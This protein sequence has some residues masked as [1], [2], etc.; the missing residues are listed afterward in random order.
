MGWTYEERVV[1][2][3][4]VA[5]EDEVLDAQNADGELPLEKCQDSRGCTDEYIDD[6]HTN[7][8]SANVQG[9]NNL[10][11]TDPC[12]Y[13]EDGFESAFLVAT[14]E[15]SASSMAGEGMGEHWWVPVWT[16]YLVLTCADSCGLV[17]HDRHFDKCGL[18]GLSKHVEKCDPSPN[19]AQLE[20][21]EERLCMRPECEQ[22]PLTQHKFYAPRSVRFLS[23]GKTLPPRRVDRYLWKKKTESHTTFRSS[24]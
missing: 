15:G 12:E 6:P 7:H 19:C 23:F 5:G 4:E 1:V 21:R 17:G 13:D 24:F 16:T 2:P 9:Y 8:A 3:S 14:A 10:S 18:E 22:L 11:E 20:P